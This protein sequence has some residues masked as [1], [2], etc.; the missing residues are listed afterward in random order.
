MV[1]S[2]S[3]QTTSL[4]ITAATGVWGGVAAFADHP[5][6]HVPFREHARHLPGFNDDQGTDL[7]LV[8][9]DGRIENG[10]SLAH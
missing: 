2:G 8:H 9:Q 6:Q 4:D 5:A 7:V 10:R 1:V 3:Q